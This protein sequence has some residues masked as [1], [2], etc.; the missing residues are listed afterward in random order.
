MGEIVDDIK[1]C[2]SQVAGGIICQHITQAG[3]MVAHQ[4]AN[5]AFLSSY[6][7]PAVLAD[8]AV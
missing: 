4:L 8:M 5:L 3:N 7:L 1:A 6:E 2:I